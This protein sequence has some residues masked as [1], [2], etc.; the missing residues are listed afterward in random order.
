[1]LITF[2]NEKEKVKYGVSLEKNTLIAKERRTSLVYSLI[3][4]DKDGITQI[5][6][7]N[8]NKDALEKLEATVDRLVSKNGGSFHYRY[9][10]YKKRMDEKNCPVCNQL[11][12]PEGE[13]DIKELKYS[14]LGASINAQ[15]KLYGKCHLTSKVHNVHF[16]DMDEDDMNNFMSDLRIV[17]KALH[18]VTEAIKI[19]YE[20]HGNSTPHLHCHLFPRYID[21]DYASMAIDYRETEPSPYKT[22]EDFN[23][24]IKRMR[25]ELDKAL[26]Q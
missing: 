17:A 23:Y 20:I 26:G 16:Y 13:V 3:T 1:M 10:S 25:Q 9:D 8:N 19:N 6:N 4:Y 12:M 22:K 11:P 5:I 2:A 7:V 24:F 15:G 21:D 14:T 18:K